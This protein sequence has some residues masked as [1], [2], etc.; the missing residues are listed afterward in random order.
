MEKLWERLGNSGGRERDV[1][2]G[3][4]MAEQ[5]RL[6]L[7]TGIPTLG[8]L[9]MVKCELFNLV[10]GNLKKSQGIRKNMLSGD[11]DI[12]TLCSVSLVLYNIKF[13]F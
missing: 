2:S 12:M 6:Y 9:A 5:L 1:Y 10:K 4:R 8:R 7:E 3:S 11:I 13:L